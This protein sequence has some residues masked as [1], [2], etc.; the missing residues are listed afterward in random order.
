[1]DKRKTLADTAQ[2]LEHTMAAR[3]QFETTT[4]TPNNT[5]DEA[6]AHA[7]LILAQEHL[8]RA[9][10]YLRGRPVGTSRGGK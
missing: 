2:A 1:M 10:E 3:A 6:T 5:P 7:N 8:T 4:R 9:L